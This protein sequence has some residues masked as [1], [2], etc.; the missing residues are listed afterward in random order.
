MRK[1]L[2]AVISVACMGFT[3]N[4]H[5]KDLGEYGHTF[6]ISE[7]N[8]L[9][10]I[11]NHLKIME[12][13]GQIEQ[14]RQE[15]TENVKKQVMRPAPVNGITT[16][17]K[18]EIKYWT[19]SFTLQSDITD[20]NGK[21]IYPRGTTVNPLD[22]STYPDQ[23][24]NAFKPMS[25]NKA[26]IF[27]DGD[28]KRQVKFA[29]SQIEQLSEQNKG[30]KLIMINGNINDISNQLQSRVYFDQN[31]VITSRMGISHVPSVA[32]QKGKSFEIKEYDISIHHNGGDHNV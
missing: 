10:V 25:Y 1:F 4:T 2:I 14:L 29:K 21:I 24:K 7:Q 13:T 32:K 8:I 11:M 15:M 18:P 23:L 31:G 26:L 12:E 9:D 16:T 19:P 30:Y 3:I 6:A 5:S 20:A 17:V 27:I 22:P 28:D